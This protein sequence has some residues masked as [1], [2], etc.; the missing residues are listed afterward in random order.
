MTA[1]AE[2][3]GTSW[4]WTLMF[5]GVGCAAAT[6]ETCHRLHELRGLT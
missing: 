6:A 2:P 5:E 3:V 1:A 4:M